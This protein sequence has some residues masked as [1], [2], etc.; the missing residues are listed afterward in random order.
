[1]QQRLNDLRSEFLDKRSRIVEWWLTA[2][3]IILEV[4][5]ILAVV[6]GYI[7]FEEIN[8]AIEGAKKARDEVSQEVERVKNIAREFALTRDEAREQLEELNA[9]IVNTN[10]SETARAAVRVRGDQTTS[11]IDRAIAAAVLLQRQGNIEEAIDQWRAIATVAGEED[12]QL[13]ARAWF[14]IG[15]L[16]AEE[17]NREAAIDV[18]TKAIALNPALVAAYTNRGAVKEALDRR[19]EAIAD[20][21]RAIALNPAYALAYN[22]R[23][24]AK[25][26]LGQPEAALADYD[27]A[28]ALNPVYA[29][30]HNNRGVANQNLGR[31]TEARADYQKAVDLAQEAGDENIV[32]AAKRNL[33][34]LDN[35]E[36]TELPG[37]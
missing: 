18:Y 21:D 36:A 30:A 15:Y 26:G 28:I 10:P 14:S 33:S 13:Q 20:Y 4:L 25:H 37:Q 3:V 11:P 29:A 12:P 9:E 31:I 34:R 16:Q 2:L 8:Q 23:G 32:T 22:N 17:G 24:F 5:S 19:E 1:M 27:Q 35:N 6:V 7:S